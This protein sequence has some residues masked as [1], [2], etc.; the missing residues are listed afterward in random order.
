[1]NSL[2]EKNAGMSTAGSSWRRILSA[3]TAV[4]FC[5]S[6]QTHAFAQDGDRADTEEF[7][8]P[9]SEMSDALQAYSEQADVE[10]LYS[11]RDVADKTTNGVDGSYSKEAALDEIIRDTDLVYEV[12]KDGVVYIRTAFIVK[13][14]EASVGELSR[15]EVRLA[16]IDTQN[17]IATDANVNDGDGED[18]ERDIIL[19]TGTNIRGIAPESSPV[20]TFDREDI[21]IT[22]AATAQDF[23]RTLPSS[24]GGGSNAGVDGLP[25]D[26]SSRFNDP[27]QG[28][29]NGSSVNLR[30]LGSG[31]TLVLLNGRRLA[32]SSG[33]GD[34]V[35]IS[36]IPASAL[37]RVEVLMD[38]ASSIYGGDAVAG[39][40]NFILRDD[41]DGAEASLRYGTVTE[42]G[43]TEKRASLTSGKAWD[44]GNAL[45]SY[46]YYNQ[47]N[48]SAADR[49]FSQGALLPND[50]LPSQERHSVLASA[51]QEVTQD[52]IVVGDFTFLTRDT[53]LFSSNLSGSPSRSTSA[54]DSWSV[55]AG[56]SWKVS[57]DWYADVSGSYSDVRT[58][59][60]FAAV[61]TTIQREIDSKLWTVDAKASGPIFRLPGGDAKLAV[62]GHYRGEG[63]SNVLLMGTGQESSADRDVYAF[64]GE[65]F[66]P[67][68]GPDSAMPGVERL[69]INVSGR[70]DD[71]SDFGS[72]INPKVGVLWSPVDGLNL[73]GSY[74]TSFNPPPL[75]RVGASDLNA[76][77]YPSA[78]FNTI[79]GQTSGDPSIADVDV[80]S[81]SGTSTNLDAE[82]SRAFTAGLGFN[83]EWGGN[84]F[85]LTSSYFDIKF[86]DRLGD[87]PVPDGSSIFNA[88]NIAFNNPELFPEGTVVFFPTLDQINDVLN[89]LSRPARAIFGADPL[90]AQIINFSNVVRNLSLTNVRGVD[91]DLAYTL[92]S[93]M[94]AF[95]LG[96]DG[97]YLIDFQ[98]Q[99]AVTTPLV[100]QLNT[101]FNPIDLTLR[102]RAGYAHKG[103]SANL[104]VNYK[105][106]YRV[107]NSV[108]A[109]DIDSWTTVDLS[110]S[111]DT[112]D[113]LGNS[114]FDDTVLRLSMINLFNEDPPATP[115]DPA[116]NVFG[117]DPT[118]AS[119]LGRFIAVEL[120]KRF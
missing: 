75:G 71:Y 94:G 22:G 70:F 67:I 50:L 9:P 119:P 38:G 27:F 46:E 3:T 28:G 39:V 92:D 77:A 29:T 64:F 63:F 84:Q 5:L 11:E 20:R 59:S 10:I 47:G 66:L 43:L 61:T 78:L 32:P 95:S 13:T 21:Q 34:F 12:N 74:S 90:S 107:D 69:E 116:F 30:G 93:E 44:S 96:L 104:F 1:V 41:F 6:I 110:L 105:D 99:A 48:L 87:T 33:I 65:A 54:S 100:E 24:F 26:D 114:V 91:F 68:I 15:R 79:L 49:S 80:L 97:T 72:T 17:E 18:D 42:G 16:Q 118:N 7:D 101:Q 81:V 103:L 112:Q 36:M 56:G 106:S 2:L 53:E 8:I 19:V 37:E 23:I 88:P 76:V 120:T 73:R 108:G 60:E 115:G 52:F 83:K 45:V 102:G 25:N 40:V 85:S 89:Q 117:Y 98:Q 82:S 57:S 86:K 111:Y 4:A 109:A 14:E 51:S 35:D 31:S 62:G 113:K 55:S 58:E